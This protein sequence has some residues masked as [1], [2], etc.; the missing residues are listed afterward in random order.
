[1]SLF[2]SLSFLALIA[3][4]NDLDNVVSVKFLESSCHD[5]LFV[6]LLSEEEAGLLQ[7]L[8]VESVCVFKDL[9][10]GLSVDVL[11]QDNLALLLDRA[12]VEAI[13]QL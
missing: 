7:A 9:A 3:K 6:V 1:V 5:N 11:S 4:S 2:L 8:T 10:H 12:Y 13:S